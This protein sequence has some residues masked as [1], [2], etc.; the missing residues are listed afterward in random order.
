MC[1]RT[2]TATSTASATKG[3]DVPVEVLDLAV[4][5]VE[6]RW[7]QL[8]SILF[9]KRTSSGKLLHISR[10]I[11]WWLQFRA[12]L[13]PTGNPK[14]KKNHGETIFPVLWFYLTMWVHRQLH[15]IVLVVTQTTRAPPWPSPWTTTLEQIRHAQHRCWTTREQPTTQQGALGCS[16]KTVWDQTQGVANW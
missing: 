2:A 11:A 12:R 5:D 7:A 15:V 14:D 16:Q 1:T 6:I 4:L 8:F 10:W 3:R 13:L 9:V